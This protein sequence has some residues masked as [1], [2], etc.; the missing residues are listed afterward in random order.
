MGHPGSVARARSGC[1]LV[2][3]CGQPAPQWGLAGLGWPLL[4]WLVSA[5]CTLIFQRVNPSVFS[6]WK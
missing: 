5:P 3:V 1:Q 6:S 2:S 4:E